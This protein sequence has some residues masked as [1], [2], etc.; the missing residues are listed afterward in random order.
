MKSFGSRIEGKGHC[1]RKAGGGS[2]RSQGSHG[3][4][5][6][7]KGIDGNQIGST[8]G[9]GFRL[10]L[11]TPSASSKLSSP[12]GSK[13]P[14]RADNSRHPSIRGFNFAGQPHDLSLSSRFCPGVHTSPDENGLILRFPAAYVAADPKVFLQEFLVR[15]RWSTI[16]WPIQPPR[17]APFCWTMVPVAHC[18]PELPFSAYAKSGSNL[19]RLPGFQDEAFTG[20]LLLHGRPES[21]GILG[22][23][24]QVL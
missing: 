4:F 6:V 11:N 5:E 7:I 20:C 23:P 9:Q 3:F 8:L 19:Y 15:F 17:A 13:F 16:H 24:I 18:E 21:F 1:D 12:A 22:H 14:C 2:H 10:F